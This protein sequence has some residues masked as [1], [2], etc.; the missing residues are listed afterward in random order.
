MQDQDHVPNSRSKSRTVW[1]ARKRNITFQKESTLGD[2]DD[3]RTVI[4]AR[5]GV[6]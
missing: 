5:D 3:R 4:G 2:E 6:L 1:H